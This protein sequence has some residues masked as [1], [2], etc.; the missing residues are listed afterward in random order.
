MIKWTLGNLERGLQRASTALQWPKFFTYLDFGVS[1][2][3]L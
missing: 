1:F 2:L 3:A